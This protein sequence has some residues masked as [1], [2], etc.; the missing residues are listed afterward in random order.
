MKKK[1]LNQ[2]VTCIIPFYNEDKY[3]VYKTPEEE[4]ADQKKE[5]E[6]MASE[7]SRRISRLARLS[8]IAAKKRLPPII[9]NREEELLSL[10]IPKLKSIM[11]EYKINFTKMKKDDMIKAILT[12][13]KISVGV[14]W[15]PRADWLYDDLKKAHRLL[16]PSSFADEYL[17]NKILFLNRQKNKLLSTPKHQSRLLR[18]EIDELTKKIGEAETLV[19]RDFEK[20]YND[21]MS[22]HVFF[23]RICLRLWALMR[24]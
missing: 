22:K 13:E 20:E 24:R 3:N 16:D 17:G 11:Y 1:S 19:K 9:S 15:D 10:N 14:R 21:Y 12:H 23:K 2:K 8:Y 4:K 7:D 5:R 18:D 6:T